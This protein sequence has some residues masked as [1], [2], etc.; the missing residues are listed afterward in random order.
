MP[1]IYCDQTLHAGGHLTLSK[2]ASRHI[3]VL[4]MQPG[5]TVH[6]FDGHGGEY[7][8]NIT[9]IGRQHVDVVV[10]LHTAVEREAS[11]AVHLAVCMPANERMDWL[12]EKAVELGVASITPLMSQRNVVKLSGERAEKKQAHW[13]AVA[14]AACEQC[15]RNLVPTIALPLSL[16]SWLKGF[17]STSHSAQRFVLSL[18]ATTAT[19]AE[20]TAAAPNATWI[21]SGP[22]GGLTAQEEALAIALG[23]APLSLGPRVLRAE[24]AALAALIRLTA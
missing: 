4:R 24:T 23:W 16:S 10:G 8:A 6:L 9:Q 11:H 19:M 15:G 2:E 20:P 7:E 12:V 1:R 21:L 14:V 5:Q 13:Q 18:Q 22:E 17:E 3:Q